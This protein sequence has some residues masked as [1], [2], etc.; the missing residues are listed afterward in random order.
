M[1]A[2]A[3][4]VDLAEAVEGA[5]HKVAKDMAEEDEEEVVAAEEAKEDKLFSL[6]WI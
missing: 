5:G 4:V 2:Q 6:G 1:M 3:E